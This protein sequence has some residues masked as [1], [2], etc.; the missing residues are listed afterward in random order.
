MEEGKG[1]WSR[2]RK[3]VPMGRDWKETVGGFVLLSMV[4]I[5]VGGCGDMEVYFFDFGEG[6]YEG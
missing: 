2:R 5:W 1:P 4:F 6:V 3:G